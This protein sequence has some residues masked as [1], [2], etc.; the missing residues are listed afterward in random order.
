[1]TNQLANDAAETTE[2]TPEVAAELAAPED[3]SQYIEQRREDEQEERPSSGDEPQPDPER[4]KASRNERRRLAREAK[5]R[6]IETLRQQLGEREPRSPEVPPLQTDGGVIDN[7]LRFAGEKHGKDKVDAAVRAFHDYVSR[8]RD[9]AAYNKVMGAPDVGEA[10]MEWHEQGGPTEQPPA[11]PYEQGRQDLER[12]MQQAGFQEALAARDEQIR[13]ATE[14]KLRVEAFAKEQPDYYETVEQ[15]NHFQIPPLML[16][17]IARSDLAPEIMFFLA[18]DVW[19]DNSQNLLAH[20]EQMQ[21]PQQIAYAFGK[22]E[23]AVR[24]AKQM[25][26]HGQQQ[27][28]TQAPPPL[29][30]VQGGANAPKDLMSLAKD[31]DVSSYVKARRSNA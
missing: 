25:T 26:G 29:R 19:A 1:M 30:P 4:K 8:T 18:K 31:D 27:R 24:Y 2:T 7:S 28:T 22:I 17:A 11:N 12:N 3:A 16:E 13:V 20:I 21:D 6:E 5:D 15:A 14:T 9:Q 10:L 23:T